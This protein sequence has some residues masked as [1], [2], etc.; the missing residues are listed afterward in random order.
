MTF[1][2]QP[3]SSTAPSSRPLRCSPCP[4]Q[5][6]A[7]HWPAPKEEQWYFVLGDPGANAALC[8]TRK[9]LLQAE[10]IGAKYAQNYVSGLLVRCPCPICGL[11]CPLGVAAMAVDPCPK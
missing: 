9:S 2:S 10:A 7:P 4:P 5:A 8:M 1:K 11:R 3:L 6:F